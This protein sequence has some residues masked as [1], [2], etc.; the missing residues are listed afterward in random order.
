MLGEVAALSAALLWAIA[1][2]VYSRLGLRVSPLALNLGK[3]LVALCLL[4]LTLLL[5]SPD[6]RP[7]DSRSLG[8]LLISGIIGIGFGDTVY[9]SAL[10]QLGARR[11]LLFEALAP[12]LAACLALILLQETL[13][14]FAWFGM[15]ITL[16][17][18]MWVISE[19]LEKSKVH[20]SWIWYRTSQHGSGCSG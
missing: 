12:P 9:L 13:S 20:C 10:K 3:G 5:Q 15:F 1:T 11:T 16:A 8:L 14:I 2:V 17:G 7:L 19:R 6:L 18:V 4:S